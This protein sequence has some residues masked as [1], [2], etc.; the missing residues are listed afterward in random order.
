[1]DVIRDLPA[2]RAALG[3]TTGGLASLLGVEARTVQRYLAQEREVPEPTWRL[4]NL[5]VDDPEARVRLN[6]MAQQQASE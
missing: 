4:L 6:R 2:I 3:L 5:V 1:L